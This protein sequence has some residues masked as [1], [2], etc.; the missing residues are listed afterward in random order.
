MKTCGITNNDNVTFIMWI[1]INIFWVLSRFL[2]RLN[3]EN[4]PVSNPNIK[5]V[6]IAHSENGTFPEPSPKI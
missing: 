4:N 5:I 2:I 6:L 1:L 3:N